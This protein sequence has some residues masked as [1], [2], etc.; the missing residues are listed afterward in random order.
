MGPRLMALRERVS[1][2]REGGAPDGFG[3]ENPAWITEH[4]CR[5]EF[6]YQSGTEAHRRG[7]LTGTAVFKVRIRACTV[8]RGITSEWRMRD[9]R[10]Q[11]DYNIREVD[12]VSD[13][14]H[15]W[16]IVESGVAV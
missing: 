5:A 14:H 10:A 7:Q 12:L 9:E 6:R 1:F 15:V 16:L 3:G 8:A 13:R 11:V 2:S 4:S